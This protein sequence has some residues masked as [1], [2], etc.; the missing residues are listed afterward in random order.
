MSV[1]I[2]D[3]RK[4]VAAK[5][6]E[7]TPHPEIIQQADSPDATTGDPRFDKMIR[8]MQEITNAIELK[9]KDIQDKTMSAP[10]PDMTALG[11]REYWFHKGKLEVIKELVKLPAMILMEE[12]PAS[13][14]SV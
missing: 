9:L 6:A 1:D 3:Y 11:Q 4:F 10:T 14:H 13:L 2:K 12:H 8:A 5:A 7:E